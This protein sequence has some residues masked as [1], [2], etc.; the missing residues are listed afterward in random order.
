METRG[1]LNHCFCTC[2]KWKQEVVC[3]IVS[4]HAI[5]LSQTVI[6]N[7][8]SCCAIDFDRCIWMSLS[9]PCCSHAKNRSVHMQVGQI[10]SAIASCWTS[11]HLCRYRMD[12]GSCCCEGQQ[13]TTKL[14]TSESPLRVWLRPHFWACSKCSSGCE[15]G[16]EE[17]HNSLAFSALCQW[18]GSI[19]WTWKLCD[20]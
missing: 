4:A 11:T 5:K 7:N 12:Y 6:A 9:I 15:A 20:K 17:T 18:Q 16:A 3:I 14:L 10:L 1:G 13:A 8:A 19:W 2:N